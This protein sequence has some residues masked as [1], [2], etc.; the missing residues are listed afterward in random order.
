[1]SPEIILDLKVLGIC[2]AIAWGATEVLKPLMKRSSKRA[3]A[4]RAVAL[5][6]GGIS[7][8]LVYPALGGEGGLI[9]GGGVGAAAGAL[10]SCIVWYLKNKVKGADNGK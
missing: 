4:L 7:G 1:M 10:D 3:S 5:L 2:A 6:V 9:V 8:A